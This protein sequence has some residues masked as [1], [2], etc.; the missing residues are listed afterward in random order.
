[1]DLWE[2]KPLTFKVTVDGLD[3]ADLVESVTVTPAS[4][5]DKFEFT[6]AEGV[7]TFKSIQS[8][9]DAVVTAT[10]KVT[11]AGTHNEVPFSLETDVVLNTNINDGAIPTNRFDV[12]FTE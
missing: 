10:A 12:E 1:M 3:V 2:S 8:A 4:I 11:V 7:Y 9:T 6:S 5:A